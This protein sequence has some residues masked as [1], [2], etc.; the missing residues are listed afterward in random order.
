MEDHLSLVRRLNSLIASRLGVPEAEVTEK[1]IHTRRAS[2]KPDHDM[3]NSAVGGR[4]TDGLEH[5]SAEQVASA[6]KTYHRMTTDH[7]DH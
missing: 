5:L 3:T 2:R 6:L 4:T 1:F 7:H